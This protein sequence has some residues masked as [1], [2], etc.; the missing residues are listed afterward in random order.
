MREGGSKVIGRKKKGKQQR[1]K[2][3]NRMNKREKRNIER[4]ERKRS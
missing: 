4:E 1:I 3:K 2:V